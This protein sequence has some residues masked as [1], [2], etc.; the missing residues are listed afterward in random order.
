M[1]TVGHDFRCPWCGRVG[2]GGYA[3]EDVGYPICTDGPVSCLFFQM[4]TRRMWALEFRMAQLGSI[5]GGPR[6]SHPLVSVLPHIA[7]FL[8]P[9]SR[10][11]TR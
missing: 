9:F 3:P 7:Q 5:L 1:G 4:D 10:W 8:V 11:G 6:G 2:N